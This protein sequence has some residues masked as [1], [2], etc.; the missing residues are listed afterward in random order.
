MLTDL[1][2]EEVGAQE[3]IRGL[4]D[5]H[6]L[7]MSDEIKK[8][9]VDMCTYTA[10]IEEKGLEEG[11]KEERLSATR[12]ML[13]FGLSKDQILKKYSEYEYFKASQELIKNT[14]AQTPSDISGGDSCHSIR[15][16][17]SFL[18]F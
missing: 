8:D 14:K 10:M 9:V 5:E 16:Y 17:F 6:H 18:W 7:P 15:D 3:K 2:N 1:F 11:R 4:E 13:E 12:T